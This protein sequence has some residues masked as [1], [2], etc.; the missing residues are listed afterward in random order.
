M[1]K[2]NKYYIDSWKRKTPKERI[3]FSD[4]IDNKVKTYTA[5]GL[6]VSLF[7]SGTFVYNGDVEI[8]ASKDVIVHF[9]K[10]IDVVDEW[11]AN[12]QK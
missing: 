3:E 8:F 12:E 7:R 4:Y 1:I 6:T 9:M 11:L 10:F 2:E 5:L